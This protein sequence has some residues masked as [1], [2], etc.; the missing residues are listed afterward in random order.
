MFILSEVGGVVVEHNHL[1]FKVQGSKRY[2]RDMR[3]GTPEE[4]YD[5]LDGVSHRGVIK[6]NEICQQ[7][8][9]A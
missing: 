5:F 7:H 2:H 6:G 1:R 3:D 9:Q 8:E 4:D